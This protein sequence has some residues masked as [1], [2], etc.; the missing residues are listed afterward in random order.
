MVNM[1]NV[2]II[3]ALFITIPFMTSC[4]K[5]VEGCTDSTANNYDA[6]AD[7]DDGSCTYDPI[8]GCTNADATNYNANAT[9]DDGS[10]IIE[11][12]TDS[13]ASNYNADATVDSGD[14]FY[15]DNTILTSLFNEGTDSGIYEADATCDGVFSTYAMILSADENNDTGFK[16]VNLHTSGTTV[17][18]TLTSTGFNIPSQTV[19]GVTFV[20]SGTIDE[21][22]SPLKINITYTATSG[23]TTQQCTVEATKQ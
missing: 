6:D 4:N 18:A 17:T 7:T 21:A 3:L 11:G 19:S 1:K 2:W 23:D 5:D 12:C 22:S 10:C 15:A 13:N 14:C 20:G 8:T 9:E 16:F